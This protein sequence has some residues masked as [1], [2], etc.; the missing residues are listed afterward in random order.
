MGNGSAICFFWP[1]R[2]KTIHDLLYLAITVVDFLTVLSISPLVVSLLNDRQAMLFENDVFCTLWS[3]VFISTARMSMFLAMTICITRT[4][5]M[6][7]PNRP[8][9]RSWVVG[10]ITGYGS[11]MIVM[12]LICIPLNWYHGRYFPH[13][14]ACGMDQDSFSFTPEVAKYFGMV[15]FFLELTLPSL[16]TFICFVVGTWFLKTQPVLG[17]ERDKTFRRVS[18]TIT[19]FTA[20]FLICNVPCFLILAWMNLWLMKVVPSPANT[21]TEVGFHYL[22]LMLQYLPIFLNAV[23]NPLL[24]L[25]RMRGYQKWIRQILHNTTT[26][27]DQD[28]VTTRVQ[29]SG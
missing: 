20:V 29:T 26:V 21:V 25:L 14:A 23:A 11:Y 28:S 15:S 10:A 12:Y 16:V 8:L 27:T 18:V 5:A 19:L 9:Q 6:K 24:Y 13:V 4:F 2:R 22:E 7:Y 3:S 1:R 17:N